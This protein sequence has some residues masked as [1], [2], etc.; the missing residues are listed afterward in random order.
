L[1]LRAQACDKS[2]CLEPRTAT[3]PLTIEVV[4]KAEEELRHPEVFKDE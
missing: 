4:E 1:K 3:L 2:R